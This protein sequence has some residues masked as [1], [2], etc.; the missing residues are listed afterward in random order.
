MKD[1]INRGGE[2]TEENGRSAGEGKEAKEKGRN[3]DD[4]KIGIRRNGRTKRRIG[5]EIKVRK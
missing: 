1:E 3:G 2:V 4:R 5:V